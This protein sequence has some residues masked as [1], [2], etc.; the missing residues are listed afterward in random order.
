[1]SQFPLIIE[2]PFRVFSGEPEY[3]EDMRGAVE[4]GRREWTYLRSFWVQQDAEVYAHL[5][6]EKYPFVKIEKKES[7]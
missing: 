6:A 4:T 3:I 5:A 2:A 7:R 1:M